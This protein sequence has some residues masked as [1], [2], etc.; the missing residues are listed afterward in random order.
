M[1]G[2]IK[3]LPDDTKI[4]MTVGDTH[5]GNK[6]LCIFADIKQGVGV[7]TAENTETLVLQNSQENYDGYIDHRDVSKDIKD[8]YWE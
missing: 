8:V 6:H 1:K 4:C 3:D 5:C 7:Y 2:F